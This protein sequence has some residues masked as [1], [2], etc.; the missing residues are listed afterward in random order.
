[1]RGARGAAVPPRVQGERDR[2]RQEWQAHDRGNS[3]R[4]D[5]VGLRGV[6]P[7]T[8]FRWLQTDLDWLVEK[9]TQGLRVR[10][11]VAAKAFKEGLGEIA[12]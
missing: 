8:G 1:M 4:G 6:V 9:L 2:D 3:V 11:G 5:A 12:Q 10:K 7:A